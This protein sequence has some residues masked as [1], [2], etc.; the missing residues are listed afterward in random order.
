MTSKLISMFYPGE[1]DNG[2]ESTGN[3]P[4]RWKVSELNDGEQMPLNRTRFHNC[5]PRCKTSQIQARL[6]LL[7]KASAL[8]LESKR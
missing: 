2:K 6:E 3:R 1:G 7:P 4:T 5:K 8:P